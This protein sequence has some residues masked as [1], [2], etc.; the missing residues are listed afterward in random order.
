MIEFILQRGQ[1]R[2]YGCLFENGLELYG[3]GEEVR[4]S[5]AKSYLFTDPSQVDLL[6]LRADSAE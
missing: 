3:A 2:Q 4:T 5:R 6:E 1:A